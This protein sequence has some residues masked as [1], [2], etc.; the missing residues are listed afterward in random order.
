MIT[1]LNY[2]TP[3]NKALTNS[4]VGDWE[5]CPNYFYRKHILGIIEKLSTKAFTVGDATDNL[6]TE[7]NKTK[8][9]AVCEHSGVTKAGKEERARHKELGRIILTKADYELIMNLAI[10]VQETDFYKQLIARGYKMQEIIQ[11]DLDGGEHFQ[12][13][14]GKP[15]FYLIEDDVC[16]IVD[17]KTTTDLDETKYFYTC[18]KYGYFR[19]L[20]IYS[21]VLK[22]NN[23]QIKEFRFKHLAV[24]KIKDIYPVQVFTLANS[25]V[26][27]EWQG[28][29]ATIMQ[30]AAEKEF[31]K[32]NPSFDNAILIGES[33]ETYWEED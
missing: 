27:Q 19:Q 7:I 10:A 1:E 3:N 12:F 14:A 6:L 16:T 25:R 5:K 31:K 23:P 30:I 32:Y 18:L 13:L 21:H 4:K 2:F 28:V 15:D 17:L 24:A 8:D 33:Q 26:E 9:Y 11:M 20:A 29:K 22:H